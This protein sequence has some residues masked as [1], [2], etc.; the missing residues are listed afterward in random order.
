MVKCVRGA[1][2]DADWRAAASRANSRDAERFPARARIDARPP[3][4][5]VRP[6]APSRPSRRARPAASCAA[7]G[8]PRRRPRTPPRGS[9]WSAGG[10]RR[11][12]ATRRESTFGTGQ[13][14]LRG[15]GPAGRAVG[16]P[17]QLDRRRRRTP[18]TRGGAHPVRHLGLDHDQPAPQ[19]RQDGQ[20]VQQHR[21]RDVVR[22]VR[23]QHRRRGGQVT[24]RRRAA[25]PR[26]PR[27]PGPRAPARGRRPS[28]AARPA[29]TGSI[30]TATTRAGARLEQGERERAEPRAHLEHHVV[31]LAARPARRSG[32]PCPARSRSSARAA[33]TAARRAARPAP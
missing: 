24:R 28:A 7:A 4:A 23:H 14:T 21:H 22:Q 20:Q 30:S 31:G 16:E 33:W 32:A 13:N 15:T 1:A 29:S 27:P 26:R 25:R 10:S 8:R 2:G 19:R 17:G 6:R 11:V 9:P 12:N 18:A 3:G 5:A